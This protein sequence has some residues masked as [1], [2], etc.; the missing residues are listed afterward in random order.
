LRVG[1]TRADG[2]SF[3]IS[4]EIRVFGLVC[5]SNEEIEKKEKIEI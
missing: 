2:F 4:A 1:G 5:T 3:K